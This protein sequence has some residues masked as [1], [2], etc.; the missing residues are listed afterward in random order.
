MVSG[1]D[2]ALKI[3]TTP[4]SWILQEK[5]YQPAER[6]VAPFMYCSNSLD[7]LK[8]NPGPIGVRFDNVSPIII[9]QFHEAFAFWNHILDIEFYDDNTESCAIEVF[10]S[11]LPDDDLV[12]IAQFPDNPMYQGQILVN[13]AATSDLTYNNY[14][15]AWIHELGHILCLRHNTNSNSIMYRRLLRNTSFQM[16]PSSFGILDNQDIK[17]LQM[18]HHIKPLYRGLNMF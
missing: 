9:Q 8:Q 4:T 13:A 15:L 12:G 11:D 17:K 18:R 1:D 5:G 2:F 10:G 6:W 3:Q 14:V 16:V 7:L